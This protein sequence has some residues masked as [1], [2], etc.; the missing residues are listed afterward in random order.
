[1]ASVVMRP[2]KRVSSG[3]SGDCQAGQSSRG[4]MT[5]GMVFR[6]LKGTSAMAFSSTSSHISRSRPGDSGTDQEC[7]S[8]R[9]SW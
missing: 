7:G 9:S 1:M 3:T 5:V 8:L 6:F 2:A 4:R